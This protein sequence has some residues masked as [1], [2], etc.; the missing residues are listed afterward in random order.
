MTE[1]GKSKLFTTKE[2]ESVGFNMVIYPVTT[3]RLAMG[4]VERGLTRIK[5]DG[6]QEATVPEMQT[7]QQLYDLTKYELYNKL[8][9]GLFNFK[10][11]QKQR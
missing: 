7:R 2:L 3:L 5:N 4:I 8:D 9:S 6:T 11:E 1:F 10:V